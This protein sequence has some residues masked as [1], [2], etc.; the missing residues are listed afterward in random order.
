MDKKKIVFYCASHPFE[1]VYKMAKM[2][3]ERDYETIL[4]TMSE[5]DRFDYKFYS[6]A[7]DR[8][9][10]SNFQF[11][12]P[13]FKSISY[14]LKRVPDFI[15]FL[16]SIKLLKPYAV[17]GVSGANWQLKLL[18][19]Y[20]FKKFPFIYFP[21]DIL[22]FSYN[23]RENALQTV[24][25]FELDAERYCFENSDGIMHKGDPEE[26]RYVNNRVHDNL[27]LPKNRLSFLPYCSDEFAVPVKNKK[28][29]KNTPLHSVYVGCFPSD[30]DFRNKLILIFKELM[31]QGIHIHAY[32]MMKHIPKEQEEMYFSDLFKDLFKN[33]LFHL[34]EPLNPKELIPVISE[35]DVGFWYSNFKTEETTEPTFATGNK[36]SSYLEAGIPYIYNDDL[37]FV[38]RLMKKYKLNLSY[39]D[40]NFKS[41]KER[42][43][44]LLMSKGMIE[45]IKR[46]REELNMKNHIKRLEEFLDK[47]SE[48]KNS[49]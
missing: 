42:I 14:I 15:K 33:N 43:Y 37:K 4:I 28:Y 39:N 21:Y 10:C 29:S 46:A 30:P 45:N 38:E 8:I 32:M 25:E 7:F 2:L 36:V 48:E 16:I 31:S 22:S 12:K 49:Q 35:Y 3:K 13:S 11:F 44:T 34:H 47:V 23:S 17:I 27:K 24:K 40:K 18:R 20:F 9:I 26:L 1:M 5:E 41:I 6:D 19:K